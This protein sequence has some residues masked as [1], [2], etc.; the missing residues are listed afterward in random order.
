MG[1]LSKVHASISKDV[2]VDHFRNHHDTED[3][4]EECYRM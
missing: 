3:F 4:E 1:F 2:V